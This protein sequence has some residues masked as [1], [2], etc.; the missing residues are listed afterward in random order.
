M[1]NDEFINSSFIIHHSSFKSK[2]N[3]LMEGHS[4]IH[5]KNVGST[6]ALPTYFTFCFEKGK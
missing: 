5:L 2:A 3:R 6:P 4:A 1:M